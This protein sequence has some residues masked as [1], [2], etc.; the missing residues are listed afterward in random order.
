MA[1]S[2]TVGLTIDFRLKPDRGRE[3]ALI[4][5]NVRVKSTATIEAG[6]LELRT[7]KFFL[8]TPASTP[9][10][11]GA[12]SIL[13]GSVNTMGSLMNSVVMRTLR[14]SIVPAT[15]TQHIGTRAGGT[16]TLS[17]LAIGA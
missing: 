9:D 15:G 13:Y 14:G 1:S 16:M 8:A 10:R 17:F 7:I 5:G 6:D 3:E 12:P 11:P 4:A 2:G